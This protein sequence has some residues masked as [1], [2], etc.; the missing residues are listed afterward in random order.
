VSTDTIIRLCLL[1]CAAA[2]MASAAVP[3]A[4][5][6]FASQRRPAADVS[7]NED[8]EFVL[9]LATRMNARGDS[10]AVKL[11]QQLIDSMLRSSAPPKKEPAA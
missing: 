4:L 6:L 10:E 3:A 5:R 2:L 11:C 9:Q 7:V 1:A 8:L